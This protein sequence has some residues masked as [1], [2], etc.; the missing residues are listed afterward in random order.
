MEYEAPQLIA[1]PSAAH[2]IEAAKRGPI[3]MD[4]LFPEEVGVG[5]HEDWE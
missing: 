4:G 1:L 5:A 2:A 3:T